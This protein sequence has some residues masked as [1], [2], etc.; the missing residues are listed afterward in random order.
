MRRLVYWPGRRPALLPSS[1]ERLRNLPQGAD[2][3][4]KRVPASIGTVASK[5]PLLVDAPFVAGNQLTG[6]VK[7][8]AKYKPQPL[9][10]PG[11]PR[12]MVPVGRFTLVT[13]SA[14]RA[15]TPHL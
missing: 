12:V 8:V 1:I 3:R 9:A 5:A 15:R 7:P 14:G 4:K 11:H 10:E 13:E 6:A 2:K